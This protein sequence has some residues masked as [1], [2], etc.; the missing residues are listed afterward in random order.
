MFLTKFYS[1]IACNC[2]AAG[3]QYSACDDY[4][5]CSCITGYAGGKCG[6]CACGLYKKLA[7]FWYICWGISALV[8]SIVLGL[9]WKFKK[10]L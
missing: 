9:M 8:V 7:G 1:F 3:S 2:D 10:F 5:R 6:V 4:G